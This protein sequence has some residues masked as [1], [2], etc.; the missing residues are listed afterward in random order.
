MCKHFRLRALSIV[1]KQ[2]LRDEREAPRDDH[3]FSSSGTSSHAF[4][5]TP[6]PSDD[7]KVGST[8]L[9]EEDSRR[10]VLRSLTSYRDSLASRSFKVAREGTFNDQQLPIRQYSSSQKRRV[11]ETL[12]DPWMLQENRGIEADSVASIS[13]RASLN[14][15]GS[16][17]TPSRL[18]FRRVNADAERPHVSAV[19]LMDSSYDSTI[20]SKTPRRKPE[21]LFRDSLLSPRGRSA[22]AKRSLFEF[23]GSRGEALNRNALLQFKMVR[24]SDTKKRH[25]Q[26]SKEKKSSRNRRDV[27]TIPLSDT[28]F[29]KFKRS[30]QQMLDE[31]HEFSP[32]SEILQTLNELTH[33]KLNT[34][35]SRDQL[36]VHYFQP[37]F[38]RIFIG[39]NQQNLDIP[40][41]PSACV[42]EYLLTKITKWIKS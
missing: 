16:S 41:P 31:D 38:L 14:K 23:R 12:S 20:N 36:F 10:K 8:D 33:S 29:S 11:D 22:I 39:R 4:N 42:W 26:Q 6:N 13:H 18:Q 5:P 21:E 19:K 7:N 32:I 34:S 40:I 3:E 30:Y 17:S 37:S 27:S 25:C 9:R 2:F 28:F 24:G 35:L 1:P 15:D